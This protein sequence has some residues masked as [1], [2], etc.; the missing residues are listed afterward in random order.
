MG[1]NTGIVT[2]NLVVNKGMTSSGSST[3][4]EVTAAN[5]TVKGENTGIVTDYLTVSG[6]NTGIE[7]DNLTE[8]LP[9]LLYLL[10]K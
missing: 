8:L 10:L 5:L 6:D 9:V 4:N 2:D 3:L 1:E 7:T